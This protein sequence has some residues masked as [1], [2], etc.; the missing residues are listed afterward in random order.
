[1]RSQCGICSCYSAGGSIGSIVRTLVFQHQYGTGLSISGTFYANYN[2]VSY[3]WIGTQS[4][5]Q[6]LGIDV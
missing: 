6:V 4:S 2:A 3:L 5:F 1:M